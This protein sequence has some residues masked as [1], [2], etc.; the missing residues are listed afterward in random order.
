M[1]PQL[2]LLPTHEME[3][4][5][6]ERLLLRV[7]R[8]V[9]GL[10]AVSLF[11]N[12][13]QAQD[14]LDVVS[15]NSSGD[16]EGVQGKKYQRFTVGDLDAAVAKF[17]DGTLPFI[18]RHLAV[19]VSCEAHERT[20]VERLMALN[21]EHADVAVELWDRQRLSEMLRNRPDIV[22]EFFG[23]STAE[24]F[25][26]PHD[27]LPIPVPGPDAVS[28]ADA[29]ALGA[30]SSGEAGRALAAAEAAEAAD[31]GDALAYVHEAQRLL[32]EAG[33]P[34]HAAVLDERVVALLT[35]LG[36]KRTRPG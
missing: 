34:A 26:A 35:R 15:I 29:V 24:S 7:A 12:S 1:N 20:I 19:G 33:F 25:C 30:T 21:K 23:A 27:V 18:V 2:R 31:P 32:T 17:V 3:W 13:G 5:D 6:F 4:P 10:R 36:R 9:R 28:T 22:I 16:H 8:E 11:G 14:G